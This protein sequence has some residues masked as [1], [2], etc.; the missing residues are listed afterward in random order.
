MVIHEFQ[1]YSYFTL[2]FVHTIKY[3]NIIIDLSYKI[4]VIKTNINKIV[5]NVSYT[6]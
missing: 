5:L 1:K 4:I 6:L 3:T 2:L